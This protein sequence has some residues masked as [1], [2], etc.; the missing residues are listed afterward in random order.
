MLTIDDIIQLVS[1]EKEKPHEIEVSVTKAVTCRNFKPSEK[2][3]EV[4]FEIGRQRHENIESKLAP[5]MIP[6]VEIA[7]NVDNKVLIKGKVDLLDLENLMVYEIKPL[8]IKAE[9]V[10]QLSLYVVI[11]R[12][13]TGINFDGGFIFYNKDKYIFE[14][15]K[16]IDTMILDEVLNALKYEHIGGNYCELCTLNSSCKKDKFWGFKYGFILVDYLRL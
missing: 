13:L 14:K 12:K 10:R 6:E 7:L 4:A 3:T 2:L 11:L 9:Y 8:K 5:S 15:V 1:R 16:F